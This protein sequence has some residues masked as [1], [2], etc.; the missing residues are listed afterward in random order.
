MNIKER[1]LEI[2]RRI[3]RALL[4]S[5]RS[6]S[7]TLIAVTKTHPESVVK[8]LFELGVEDVGEN[9]VQEMLKKMELSIPVRW[10]F[11]GGLQRNKVKYIIGKVFL[12]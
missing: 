11:I 5:K 7:V 8:E 6:D 9:Y 2:K 10:H 4:I 3:E 1:L 12:I